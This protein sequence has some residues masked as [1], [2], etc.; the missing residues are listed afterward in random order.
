ME[1]TA[2]H[3]R[4]MRQLGEDVAEIGQGRLIKFK[5]FKGLSGRAG[6]S[7]V[8]SKYQFGCLTFEIG[9]LT[10]SRVC[11]RVRFR[12]LRQSGSSS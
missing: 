8:N 1:G 10:D 4:N 7:E 3:G 11:L 6:W 9:L 12:R 5:L 2:L